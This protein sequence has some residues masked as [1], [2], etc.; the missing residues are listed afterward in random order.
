MALLLPLRLS[1]VTLTSAR[2]W[3]GRS[4]KSPTGTT[5][6]SGFLKS[7]Q[8]V[9]GS[10]GDEN[11]ENVVPG[12]STVF[13][14][15]FLVRSTELL[16]GEP[17]QG[18]LTGGL[19]FGRGT[20]SYKNGQIVGEQIVKDVDDFLK[21]IES[22]EEPDL[23]LYTDEL[24]KIVVPTDPAQRA[25]HLQKLRLLVTDYEFERRYIAVKI[26]GSVRDLDN[27]PALIYA[28]TDPA[29]DVVVLAH[30]GLRFISRKID[31]IELPA[32]PNETNMK[33]VKQQWID[34]YRSVRPDGE[35]YYE[36]ETR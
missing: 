36:E 30:Q 3:K 2:S 13:A 23:A 26:L 19:G 10:W 11:G 16:A 5:R 35:L 9:D 15:L 20:L 18:L 4:T 6:G 24:T 14:I 33:L 27:V 21:A 7:R 31:S 1:S 25:Q 8:T 29:A 17:A 22:G 34:W 12:V 32:K 28:L